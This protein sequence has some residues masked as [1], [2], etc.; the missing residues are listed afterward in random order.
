MGDKKIMP[1]GKYELCYFDE[2][3]NDYLEYIVDKFNEGWVRDEAE[4]ELKK[5]DK[6]NEWW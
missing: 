4:K 6:E 3:P 1:F 5:R 2:I